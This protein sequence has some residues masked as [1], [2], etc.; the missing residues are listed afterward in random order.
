VEA[1]DGSDG[2]NLDGTSVMFDEPCRDV[3]KLPVAPPPAEK[4]NQ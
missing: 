2:L 4:E 1:A 3:I